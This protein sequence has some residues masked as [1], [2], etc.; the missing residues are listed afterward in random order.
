MCQERLLTVLSLAYLFLYCPG[1]QLLCNAPCLCDQSSVSF[2]TIRT[3][4]FLTIPLQSSVFLKAFCLLPKHN[5]DLLNNGIYFLTNLGS[6]SKIKFLSELISLEKLRGRMN[7]FISSCRRLLGA[8]C[9]S[10]HHTLAALCGDPFFKVSPL[11]FL[12]RCE[13]CGDTT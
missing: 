3:L 6:K 13:L 12:G 8:V 1:F 9:S 11:W 2:S 10:W 5:Q 7:S 4:Q